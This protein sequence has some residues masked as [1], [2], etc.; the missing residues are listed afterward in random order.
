MGVVVMLLDVWVFDVIGY[1]C[2]LV[3]M[4]I[5]LDVVVIVIQKVYLVVQVINLVVVV[6][7]VLNYFG[8]L[9]IGVVMF[10]ILEVLQVVVN[11]LCDNGFD[12]VFVGIFGQFEEVVV[13][14]IFLV[15]VKVVICV[16]GVDLVVEVVFVFC[17]NLCIFFVIVVCEQDLGKLVLSLN[18]VF[19]WY[20]MIFVGLFIFIYGL[21]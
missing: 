15:L 17:M 18:F 4:V 12:L 19:V 21:G 20:M 7:V 11:L 16:V 9:W 6:V 3:L 13:V 5:G 10:Y 1:G 2:M 8:V 14:C